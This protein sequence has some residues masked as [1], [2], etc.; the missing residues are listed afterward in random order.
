MHDFSRAAPPIPLSRACQA[1]PQDLVR[2]VRLSDGRVLTIRPIRPEDAAIEQDFVKGLSVQARYLRFMSAIAELTPEML[3]YFTQIDYARAMALIAVQPTLQ[4]ERQV[5]VA[6]Y[7]V[8]PDG[9]TC[10]FAIVVG[11]DWQGKGL[12]Y[13]L[14]QSLIG[15]AC[16]RGLGVMEGIRLRQNARM[17][18]LAR[19]LGFES[20]QDPDDPALIRMRRV[21]QR[22][23]GVIGPVEP[24][25][26]AEGT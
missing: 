15:A 16:S 6:R 12:A 4:G 8:L 5:G 3:S 22:T 11:D 23:R 1:Y 25:F 19:S 21:L 13:Q 17:R 18:D 9:Q 14:M 24:E 10:E 20:A 7:A 2:S 26:A